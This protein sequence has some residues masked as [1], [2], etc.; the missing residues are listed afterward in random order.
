[1]L[2]HTFSVISSF[3]MPLIPTLAHAQAYFFG[4]FLIWYA[5]DATAGSYAGI[6][7]RLFPH[8]VCLSYQHMR[9]L[10]HTFSIISSFDMPLI[11]PLAR[12]QAYFFGYFLI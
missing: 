3:G 9:M 11:P 8:S 1:M 4:Y 5:S 7:F 6:L 10:R 12:T 2:R